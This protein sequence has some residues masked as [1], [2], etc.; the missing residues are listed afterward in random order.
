MWRYLQDRIG[1]Q[2]AR[3]K[4]SC[5]LQCFIGGGF[6]EIV[7]FGVSEESE[8]AYAQAAVGDFADAGASEGFDG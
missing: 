2:T 7:D 1:R 8:L 4:A 6:S 3:R 5:G